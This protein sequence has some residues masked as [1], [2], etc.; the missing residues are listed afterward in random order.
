V[1]IYGNELAGIL[2]KEAARSKH[3]N[4]VFRRIPISTLYHEIKLESTHLWQKEW[5]NGTRAAT[6][7]EYFPTV[8]DRLKTKMRVT[9]NIAAMLMGHGKTRAYL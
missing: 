2:A 4:I 1:G 3:T 7:K 8:Q 6:T 9:Q 5:E